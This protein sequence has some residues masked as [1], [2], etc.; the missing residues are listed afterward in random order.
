MK[1]LQDT[2]EKLQKYDSRFS[3]GQSYF[4]SDGAQPDLIFH[5]LSYTLRRILFTVILFTIIGL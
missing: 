4:F 2:V 3:I 1:K 5:T